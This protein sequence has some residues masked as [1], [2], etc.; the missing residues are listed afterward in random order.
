MT[1]PN[2]VLANMRQ[3]YKAKSLTEKESSGDPF[4]QFSK[5]FNEA[6]EAQ[7]HEPNA[8]TLAT[9][10]P[11]N[12]PSARI[13]L[14]KG[15][16]EMG[17]CFY[18][19]YLSRKG[20][21]ISKN[22]FA[23]IVFYWGDLERQVRIE[24]KIEKLSKERSEAYF[25]TRPVGSQ[26]GALVSPQSQLLPDRMVLEKRLELAASE[27]EG[28]VIPKPA[29]WGGYRVVPFAVEFWQGR[30]NRLHDRLEYVLM[31]KGKWKIQRLAP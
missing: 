21:E 8:M 28:K 10:G 29:H 26:L 17:F 23:S 1:I 25:H 6:M 12:R 5:W 3:E 16:D 30:P 18:T 27:Y 14:L 15:F 22:P 31:E 9:V 2:D 13:V 20:K 11:N 7:I 4:K 24:G 19:N